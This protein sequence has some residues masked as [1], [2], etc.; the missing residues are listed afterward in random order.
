[1]SMSLFHAPLEAAKDCIGARLCA[2]C[3][4]QR[5]DVFAVDNLDVVVPYP[6]C[7][8]QVAL[9]CAAHHA[10]RCPRCRGGVA[11]AGAATLDAICSVC[12]GAGR[13]AF[14]HETE[15]GEISWEGLHGPKSGDRGGP[16][17]PSSSSD[18][19]GAAAQVADEVDDE[20]DS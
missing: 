16:C 2:L 7:S 8:A 20:E 17:G 14:G 1:M 18:V 10:N 19:A 3:G 4:E 9:A 13:A 12:I 6:A 15:A 5:A 11:R